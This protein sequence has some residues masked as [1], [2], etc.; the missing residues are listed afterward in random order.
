MLFND[1]FLFCTLFA[2]LLLHTDCRKQ[3][4]CPVMTMTS[5]EM[6]C[7]FCLTLL[8]YVALATEPLFTWFPLQTLSETV[9]YDPPRQLLRPVSALEVVQ[10]VSQ[11]NKKSHTNS[12]GSEDLSKLPFERLRRCASSLLYCFML[13]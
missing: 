7:I 3:L 12:I 2:L 1:S 6:L 10:R 8:S 9:Y 4:R 5:F 13:V 11:D